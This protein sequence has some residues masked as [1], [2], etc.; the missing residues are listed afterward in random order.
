ML[1][2]TATHCGL[3]CI[4]RGWFSQPT[5]CRIYFQLLQSKHTLT[6]F[7]AIHAATQLDC[8]SHI[9]GSPHAAAQLDVNY[10]WLSSVWTLS[11]W[12][13][14][15]KYARVSVFVQHNANDQTPSNSLNYW[16][17]VSRVYL[18]SQRVGCP[19]WRPTTK[20]LDWFSKCLSYCDWRVASS[21]STYCCLVTWPA[22]S[23]A[24]SYLN[25]WSE[26]SGYIYFT[27]KSCWIAC[28]TFWFVNIPYC[29]SGN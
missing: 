4:R 26:V 14:A 6:F 1:R 29:R 13:P 21:C 11:I 20:M 18:F 27:A 15:K 8:G 7:G 28:N 23:S 2:P 19:Q 3:I 5:N 22:A 24:S 10:I 16:C 25:Y 9:S 17:K 12:T